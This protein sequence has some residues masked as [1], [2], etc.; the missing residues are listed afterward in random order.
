[1]IK[2]R[3][4]TAVAVAEDGADAAATVIMNGKTTE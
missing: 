3:R 2:T 4:I 1:M